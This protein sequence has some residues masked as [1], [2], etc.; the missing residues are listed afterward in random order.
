MNRKPQSLEAVRANVLVDVEKRLADFF[1]GEERRIRRTSFQGLDHDELAKILWHAQE[2][3]SEIR[4]QALLRV[5]IEIR[6]LQACNERM[7]DSEEPRPIGKRLILECLAM[8]GDRPPS[9]EASVTT[10]C[11]HLTA[12]DSAHRSNQWQLETS[13]KPGWQSASATTTLARH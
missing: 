1:D 3:L 11:G 5:S 9:S 13:A 2:V 4:Q 10:Q 7:Q 12:R 8:S 6:W